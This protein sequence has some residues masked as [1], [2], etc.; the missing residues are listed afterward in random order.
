MNIIFIINCMGSFKA[1][2]K[3]IEDNNC[4]LYRLEER[5]VLSDK[6]L[7]FPK[8]K[9]SCLILV[10]EMT[11]LLFKLL[12]EAE[13]VDVHENQQRVFSCSGCTGLIK[14]IR[15]DSNA[16]DG[17]A[18]EDFSL[19]AQQ[20]IL[21]AKIS[22][23]SL[24]KALAHDQLKRFI[25]CVHEHIVPPGTSII[26]KGE[27]NERLYILLSGEVCVEDD[28]VRIT[29]LH[30][31]E[32][33]GE[34]SYFG[35]K[36]ARSTVRATKETKVISISGD[37]F[38]RFISEAPSVQLYMVRLLAERLAKANK[39]RALEFDA[40]MHGRL[41]DMAPAELFQIFHMHQKTG[42]LSLDLSRG[43]AKV[44]F[45][46]GCIINASYAGQQNQEAIFSILAEKEG[47]YRFTV[48]LSPKEMKAAEIGDFMMLLME[49]VK[50]VDEVNDSGALS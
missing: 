12:D 4:P 8:D 19:N 10:R 13:Q 21:L 7:T 5:L 39:A 27:I 41:K 18:Q 29:T 25:G 34:M 32:V 1:V 42:A 38:G 20:H 22:G 24:V 36:I 48:G 3:I 37:D 46:Q 50:R 45:R 44:S 6:A 30:E 11:E 9:E 14:F 23:Y 43:N 47:L 31:G 28:Q 35:N 40:C 26:T 15:V 33:C 16:E 49:G 17:R 2:F